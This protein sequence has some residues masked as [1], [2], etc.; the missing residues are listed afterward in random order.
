[1]TPREEAHAAHDAASL[2]GAAICNAAWAAAT[3]EYDATMRPLYEAH[4]K[5]EITQEALTNAMIKADGRRDRVDQRADAAYAKVMKAAHEALLA[6]LQD[7][8]ITKI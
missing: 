1:M 2:A 4:R 8:E 5:G 6:A 3:D 7:D